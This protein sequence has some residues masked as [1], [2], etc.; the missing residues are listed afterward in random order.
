MWRP[1]CGQCCPLW[2]RQ[3]YWN[4]DTCLLKHTAV[5]W[6]RDGGAPSLL[7]PSVQLCLFGGGG[8]RAGRMADPLL[9]RRPRT[10]SA[11]FRINF[12]LQMKRLPNHV[13]SV[14]FIASLILRR[15]EQTGCNFCYI[16]LCDARVVAYCS[17]LTREVFRVM[18]ISATLLMIWTLRKLYGYFFVLWN[19][20]FSICVDPLINLMCVKSALRKVLS[21]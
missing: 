8:N 10:G 12:P 3:L 11:W 18:G 13:P 16:I 17:E 1:H 9:R 2:Q 6:S 21:G 7:C 14:I 5:M 20:L 4:C 15:N 19:Q